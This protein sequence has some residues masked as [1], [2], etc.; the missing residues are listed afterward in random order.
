LPGGASFSR[1]TE[2]FPR[3][4]VIQREIAKT[5]AWKRS[6]PEASVT[7]RPH[8]LLLQPVGDDDAAAER[9][10]AQQATLR[11]QR[12]AFLF[13]SGGDLNQ[14]C[15]N[16]IAA[17]GAWHTRYQARRQIPAH[18]QIYRGRPAWLRPHSQQ[19][20]IGLPRDPA[21]RDASAGVSFC[22]FP[23][24]TAARSGRGDTGNWFAAS[25]SLRYPVLE[26]TQCREIDPDG[27]CLD[28]VRRAV[29]TTSKE[30]MNLPTPLSP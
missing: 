23:L 4:W 18:P 17:R 13:Y 30:P 19:T 27:R 28:G 2:Y 14:I 20:A 8:G 24:D 6:S 3:K 5:R 22:S 12:P 21:L 16:R 9:H 15:G 1:A 29:A 26:L 25:K 7:V 11:L 10:A